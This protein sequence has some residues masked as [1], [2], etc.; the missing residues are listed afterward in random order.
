MVLES[1][2]LRKNGKETGEDCV[3]RSFMIYA[4]HQM[5]FRYNQRG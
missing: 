2:M 3:M 1:R 4:P 5:L